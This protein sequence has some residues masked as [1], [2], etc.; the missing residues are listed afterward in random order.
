MPDFA[1]I[2]FK[3]DCYRCCGF[4]VCGFAFGF[5]GLG[6]LLECFV[7]LVLLPGSR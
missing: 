6:Y 3:W 2:V 1:L 7:F 5:G 4:R